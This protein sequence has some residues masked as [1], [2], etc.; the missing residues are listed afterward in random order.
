MR[1][2]LPTCRARPV[3]D[4]GVGSR[5]PDLPAAPRGPDPLRPVITRTAEVPSNP[6]SL[7]WRARS[8]RAS[9]GVGRPALR[10]W[11]AAVFT[12]LLLAVGAPPAVAH[13]FLASTR[14]DQGARL[15]GPPGEVALQLS[16]PVEPGSALVEVTNGRGELV[17]VGRLEFERDGAVVR[18]PLVSPSEG[19]YRV[20]WHVVSAIDG[21][22]SAGEFAFAV[23]DEVALSS[24]TTGDRQT[25]QPSLL[26]TAATWVLLAG[27]SIAFGAAMLAQ[28]AP[29]L[30]F[31]G[32]PRTWI[33]IGAS[34]S[35]V[36]LAVRMSDGAGQRATTVALAAAMSLAVA[37]GLSASRRPW[38][39]LTA[40]AAFAIV[41]PGRGHA[42]VSPR[43]WVLD[44]LHLAAA[45]LWIGG[46]TVV[47]IGL[48][49][50]ARQGEADDV[51]PLVRA[52][53]RMALVAAFALV[54]TGL[55][56]GWMLV[57]TLRAPL[58]SGYG[59]LVALK[60]AA[61]TLAVAAAVLAR[62]GLT[63]R[64]TG[65]LR[66]TIR[67]EH[68]ALGVALVMAAMLVDTPPRQATIDT[69]LGPPPIL[70][71][72]VRAASLAGQ[73][74][75]DVQVGDGRL[76]VNV[77]GSSG[78]IDASLTLTATLP[79]GTRVE[80]HPR[81]CGVG[82]STLAL[83]LP[84]GESQLTASA[85]ASDWIGGT[86]TLGLRWPP[87]AEDPMLFERMRQA[88]QAAGEVIVA[89]R[90]SAYPEPGSDGAPLTGPRLVSLLPWGGGGVSDVRPVPDEP[91][92]F[93]FYLPGSH[94]WFDVTV[95][96]HDR[97][98]TQRIV[99]PGHDIRYRLRYPPRT[100]A[101]AQSPTS[102]DPG[103]I[104]AIPAPSA[105]SR[106]TR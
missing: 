78:G 19:L 23:G 86:T 41:W 39:A 75:L 59:R 20:S 61:A 17:E 18:L 52:Y 51:L 53:A 31:P 8:G 93:T 34:T 76:D 14:P 71:P 96:E 103:S 69:L 38:P 54:A 9:T 12:V 100:P 50:G 21:H 74:T 10:R 85:E 36:G 65:L 35:L 26:V 2:I 4:D 68:L 44:S 73:L 99:N 27:W 81:P 1:R 6:R 58:A 106:S 22:E 32:E 70:G 80:L 94:M 33:R 95:D 15:P 37:L 7:V 5:V 48:V 64:D 13:S 3:A 82:C 89:E 62:R 104:T 88:T 98:L 72:T 29:G 66:R 47:V 83:E 97:L 105:G 102:T 60:L 57:P 92:R 55:A 49:A 91:G 77:R 40:L 30:R 24:T 42:A 16:E 79:D 11:S 101:A 56:L 46:L 28:R 45:G 90:A 67:P 25:S 87:P 63:R 84:P 43:G